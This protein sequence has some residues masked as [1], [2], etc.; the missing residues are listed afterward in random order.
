[1]TLRLIGMREPP[2]AGLVTHDPLELVVG[3]QSVSAILNKAEH[4]L[5]RIFIDPAVGHARADFGEQIVLLEWPRTSARHDVLR[6]HIEPARAKVLAV[7]LSLIDGVF[8]RHR[9]EKLEAVAGDQHCTAGGVEPVTRAT[10]P[11]EQA[12]RALGC[13]HLHDEV[14]IAPIDTEIEARGSNQ[15]TQFAARHGFLDLA[16]RLLRQ[17]AMMHADRHVIL[18]HIPQTLEDV[19]G[20]KARVGEDQCCSIV[21]D[22]FVELIDRPPTRMPAPRHALLDR[23]QNLD[24]RFGPFFAQHQVRCDNLPCPVDRL[25]CQP[26]PKRQRICQ[27]RGKGNPLGARSDRVEPGQGQSQQIAALAGRECVNLVDHH[28][29]EAGEQVDALGIGQ[30]Q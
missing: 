25:R 4:A 9:F 10:D 23:E 18:V 3:A 11:L 8:R 1:M 7:A 30:Q 20:E 6:E 15:S 16:P 21:L 22:R 17:A 29:L 5:E 26:F 14:D 19:F 27:G 13:A 2:Y 12:R 28:S 24:F